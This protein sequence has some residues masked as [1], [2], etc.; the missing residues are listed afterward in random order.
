MTDPT[1]PLA[2]G[3]FATR[4]VDKPWGRELIWSLTERY[5]G[6]IITI[7]IER[8]DAVATWSEAR[9]RAELECLSR[10]APVGAARAAFGRSI[11][12]ERRDRGGGSVRR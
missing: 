7:E 3:A 8:L 6:K 9:D 2:P 4:Q 11:R 10:V 5:C 12:H 1:D